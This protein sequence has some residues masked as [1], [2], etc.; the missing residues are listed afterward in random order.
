L[1]YRRIACAL[2]SALADPER[3]ASMGGPGA[4]YTAKHL[5][6]LLW[7]G[8]ALTTA[9]ALFLAHR[10][11]STWRRCSRRFQAALQPAASTVTIS[12][13][14]SL[15]ITAPRS[16]WLAPVRNSPRG[17]RAG[18][19]ARGSDGRA[20]GPVPGSSAKPTSTPLGRGGPPTLTA[21]LTGGSSSGGGWWPP[22]ISLWGLT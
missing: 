12:A 16:D 7:F 2:V 4:G 21:Q 10:E 18:G 20:G 22:W 3:I 1:P 19:E 13:P 8:Q 11:G 17:H 14:F 5:I 9:E 6:N 15:A